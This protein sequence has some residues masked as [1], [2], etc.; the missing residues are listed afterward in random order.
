MILNYLPL[1]LSRR[2]ANYITRS[3]LYFENNFLKIAK[4][5]MIA[6]PRYH[7]FFKKNLNYE[8]VSYLYLIHA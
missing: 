1:I 4:R 7:D 6:A 2:R 5:C 3:L 8:E